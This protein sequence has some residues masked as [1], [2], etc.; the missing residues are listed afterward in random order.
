MKPQ[1]EVGK[2]QIGKNGLVKESFDKKLL[3][4]DFNHY[5]SNE[6]AFVS[7]VIESPV[8]GRTGNIEFL[9]HL[10]KMENK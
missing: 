6:G 1:F 9:F 7:E 8:P 2:E 5:F 10:K 3:V 4:E